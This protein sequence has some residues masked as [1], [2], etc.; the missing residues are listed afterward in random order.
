MYWAKWE[1]NR[2]TNGNPWETLL[3]VYHFSL[4]I[5]KVKTTRFKEVTPFSLFLF[6]LLFCLSIYIVQKGLVSVLTLDRRRFFTSLLLGHTGWNSVGKF[7]N[8][9]WRDQKICT[10]LYQ[11]RSGNIRLFLRHFTLARSCWW[12]IPNP[13]FLRPVRQPA[14]RPCFSHHTS[15]FYILGPAAVDVP[16]HAIYCSRYVLWL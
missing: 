11:K 8:K 15:R 2:L 6:C 5:L 12:A 14:K 3:L 4:S 9:N 10:P 7:N 13:G 16:D 1:S